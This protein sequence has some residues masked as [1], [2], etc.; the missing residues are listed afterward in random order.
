[1]AFAKT[2]LDDLGK[3]LSPAGTANPRDFMDARFV[4]ELDKSGY[5]DGLYADFVD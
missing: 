1:L 2:V 5:I 4:Q 3:K